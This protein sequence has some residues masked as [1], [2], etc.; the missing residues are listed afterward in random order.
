M[1]P[2]S[3]RTFLLRSAEVGLGVAAA[4]LVG[5]R[6]LR[7]DEDP[8]NARAF[9]PLGDSR[10]AVLPATSYVGDLEGT[11]ADGLRAVGA[12]L[13]GRSVL[14]KPN[15]VEFDAGTVIN[16]DPR[17]VAATVVAVRRLGA[18]D[19]VVGEGP[20]H[21]RDTEFVV[22]ASGLA[23]ALQAVEAPFTDLNT[24]AMAPR[25]L[26]SRYTG[27]RDLW[28][29]EPVL[30][31]D[32]VISMP[33]MKTHHWAGVTLSMKNLFGTMPS[34]LYGWPKNVLHWVGIAQ[35]IL[36]ITG[37]VRPAYAIVDGIVGMEG[38][39]PIKGTPVEAGVLVFG[40]DP[41][42]TDV[43][44]TMVMGLD[45]ER[46]DYLVE[47]GRF[48]GQGDPAKIRQEG[49]DPEAVAVPFSVLPRWRRLQVGAPA[50]DG[51]GGPD[52]PA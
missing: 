17:L 32:V 13:Q 46:V 16:T 49:E 21:R 24:A 5:A 9:P 1:T 41:V 42:S 29:P 50:D 15:L 47:A 25:H 35:S 45:P 18:L 30:D 8:W 22:A 37:A 19:V 27:L 10:V 28:L 40:N 20:G 34:R 6:L 2:V 12:D 52:A 43:T 51:S 31:A 36:D 14:L 4:G 44:A 3:R 26:E 7:D 39:G 38:D 33:K 23:D 11:V 48:L